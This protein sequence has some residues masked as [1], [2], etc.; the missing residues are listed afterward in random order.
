MRKKAVGSGAVRLLFRLMGSFLLDVK[1]K[2]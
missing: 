2:M 1:K